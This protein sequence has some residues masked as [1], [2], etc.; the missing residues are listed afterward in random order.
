VLVVV[1]DSGAAELVSELLTH[2]GCEVTVCRQAHSALDAI[3]ELPA[4]ELVLLDDELSGPG[5]REIL[6]EMRRDVSI[7]WIPVVLLSSAGDDETNIDATDR[8]SKKDLAD[9]LRKVVARL[10]DERPSLVA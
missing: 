9:G 2:A 7:S 8:V 5:A 1:E 10:R 6:R 4:P 3:R